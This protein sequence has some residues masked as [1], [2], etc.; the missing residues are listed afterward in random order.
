MYRCAGL[1]IEHGANT[2]TDLILSTALWGKHNTRIVE[3]FLSLVKPKFQMSLQKASNASHI[4][5]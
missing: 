4:F 2:A 1:C 5:C 3:D